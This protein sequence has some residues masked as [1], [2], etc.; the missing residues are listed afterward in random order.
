M[1]AEKVKESAP[2][3]PISENNMISKTSNKDEK[4]EEK[5]M[6]VEDREEDMRKVEHVSKKRKGLD[7]E[8]FGVSA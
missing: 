5:D 4:E 7:G 6:S 3:Q 2:L 1:D 8:S